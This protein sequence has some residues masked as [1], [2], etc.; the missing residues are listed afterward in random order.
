MIATILNGTPPEGGFSGE[1]AGIMLDEL[2]LRHFDA[3]DMP[4]ARMDIAPCRGCFGCWVR[5]PGECIIADA[6]R[7]VARAMIGS[8]LAVWLTPVRFGGYGSTLKR[9]MDRIIPLISPHFRFVDG[10]IH[11][12][13]RYR[14]YPRLL[15][16]GV[17]PRADAEAGRLFGTLVTRNAINMHA[18]AHVTGLVTAEDGPEVARTQISFWLD[19]LEVTE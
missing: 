14:H 18:P 11:H 7:D 13:K 1:V 3:L 6:G 16:L 4:L 2:K 12:R 19:E 15:A 10:E 17:L 9:A 5:T 8:D